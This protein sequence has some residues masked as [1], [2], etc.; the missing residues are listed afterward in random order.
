MHIYTKY[1]YIK[2]ID[3]LF[4]FLPEVPSSKFGFCQRERSLSHHL[5]HLSLSLGGKKMTT[6]VRLVNDNIAQCGVTE[7]LR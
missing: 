7:I 5:S 1:I 2:N 4:C 3:I 6:F